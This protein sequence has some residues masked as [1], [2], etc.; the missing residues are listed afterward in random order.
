M[1]DPERYVTRWQTA[2]FLNQETVSAILSWEQA[3][4]KPSGRQWQVLVALI[5]GGILL[6]AGVLLFVAAHWDSASP[7]TRTTIVLAMLIFFHGFGIA[8]HEIFPSLATAMHA[9]GT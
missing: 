4:K 5:L 7:L 8:V 6:G 9:V 3:H 2:G 1:E